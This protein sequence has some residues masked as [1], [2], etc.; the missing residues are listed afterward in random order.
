MGTLKLKYHILFETKQNPINVSMPYR[1]LL[2]PMK[3]V[4]L[5]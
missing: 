3:T 1:I 5:H 2:K 4:H